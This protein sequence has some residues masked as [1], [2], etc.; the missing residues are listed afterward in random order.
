MRETVRCYNGMVT[1]PHA[2]AS[3]AGL[4]VLRAGGNAVEAAVATA[5]AIA[6]VYPHMTGIG[7]DGFW[8]IA[9]PGVAPIAIDAAGPAAA[10][11]T[12]ERYRGL[13]RLPTRG[14]GAALTVPGTI[15]GWAAALAHAERWGAG[16]PL[17]RI[18]ADAIAYARDGV[19]VTPSQ[20]R[21]SEDK[22]ADLSDQPGFAA[23]YLIDGVAP[24]AGARFCQPALAA[25]LARLAE[26][27]L[28]DFYRGELAAALAADLA[29]AGSPL[30]ASDFAQ[31]RARIVAPLSVS[32]PIGT[33][34]VLPPPTQGFC[35]AMILGILAR[36][37][38]DRADDVHFVHTLVE[39]TK[40]AFRVRDAELAD[41]L[42]MRVDVAEQLSSFVLAR[43][44]A[45]IAPNRAAPWP[46]PEDEGGTIWL[47]VI[48]GEGRAVSLI[49]S[50][51]WEFGSGVV[52][53]RTGVVLQNRGAG[54]SLDPQHP[55]HLTPGRRPYH[56]LNP[57]FARLKDG[58]D[59]VFGTMGGD[60]QPQ[61]QAAVFARYA[62]FGQEPQRAVSAPRWLL[63]RTWGAD[64]VTLKLEADWPDTL[65]S[66]LETIGHPVERLPVWSDTCGH[67]GLI[68][69]HAN[70][71]LEG[72]SDPRSDGRVAGW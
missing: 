28:D 38:L 66:Q 33:V 22:L 12:P 15:S 4:A 70:G 42:S 31:Q 63:G 19:P 5:A 68:A 9:E 46:M 37:P 32:L 23:T 11:A 53:P 71:L 3:E 2:L 67:A 36:M 25:T 7:G 13:D 60:G 20:A 47:G 49:Q 41:P 64:S 30:A 43:E 26:A 21:Y 48:D 62:L 10:A 61:F 39:A 24:R 58:R 59:V 29:A 45:A 44:A 55:N 40:R 56:T 14:P 34:H 51:Y 6:V 1:S 27:G 57:S 52:S 54:F 16:L 72:A 65:I 17:D 35:T 18:L 50:L 69:R 8:I